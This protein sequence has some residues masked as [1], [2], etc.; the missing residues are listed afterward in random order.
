MA[1]RVLGEGEQGQI[2]GIA[3]P[4]EL[5]TYSVNEVIWLKG[6]RQEWWKGVRFQD[7]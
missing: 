6:G 3:K 7:R 1:G 5:A 4:G 2:Q